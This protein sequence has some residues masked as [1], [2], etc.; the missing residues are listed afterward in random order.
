METEGAGRSGNLPDLR[1]LIVDDEPLIRWSM[2]ET[3]KLAGVAVLEAGSAGE[4]LQR[5]VGDLAPDVVLLD[6]RLPDSDDLTLLATIRR[7]LPQSAVV[8]I[9]AFGSPEM[10]QGAERLGV[11]RVVG[12]PLE[13]E[14]LLPLVQEAYAARLH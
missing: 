2:A 5:I 3:L 1:V 10:V 6:Y 13:M 14:E 12:K 8:M 11:F 9:T 7:R 4:T